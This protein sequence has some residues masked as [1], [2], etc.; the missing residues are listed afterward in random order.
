MFAAIWAFMQNRWGRVLALSCVGLFFREFLIIPPILLCF[1]TFWHILC[2]HD[3]RKNVLWLLMTLSLVSL[4]VIVPRLLIPVTDNIGTTFDATSLNHLLQD[5]IR[6]F[7]SQERW[8]RYLYATLSVIFPALL[9][10][11]TDRLRHILPNMRSQILPLLIYS[12]VVLVLS[13]HGG[14]DTGRFFSYLFIPMLFILFAIVKY[15]RVLSL[16][17]GF[18][19]LF[20]ALFNRVFWA[21]PLETDAY[22]DR[23]IMLFRPEMVWRF[24]EIALYIVLMILVRRG[25]Q[26][27]IHRR[28]SASVHRA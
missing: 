16:E 10:I 21:I 6:P 27:V 26:F 23:I 9:M 3:R 25:A 4:V 1:I 22:A 24:A 17:S 19:I 28:R 5:L 14:S 7:R 18:V 11:N 12:L 13:A 8:L 20:T 2:N 15:A